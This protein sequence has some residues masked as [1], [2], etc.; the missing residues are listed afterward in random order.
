MSC[1]AAIIGIAGGSVGGFVLLGTLYPELYGACAYQC[2][3]AFS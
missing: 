2:Y 3:Y 1:A